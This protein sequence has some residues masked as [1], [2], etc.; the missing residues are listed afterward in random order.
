[1]ALPI[2]FL[3]AAVAGG[4]R[5]QSVRVYSEFQRVDPF[6]AVIAADKADRPRE[7]LSPAVPRNAFV[8]FQAVIAV[9]EGQQYSLFLG[10]NPENA[11]KV[12]AYR[13]VWVKRGDAYIP[14]TLE[15]LEIRDTG[16]VVDDPAVRLPGQ[17][18]RVIWLDLWVPADAP[19]RRTRFEVQMNVGS[20]W[21]IYP[22]ELR[23]S[24]LV[25]PAQQG[26]FEPLPPPEAPASEAAA[27]V[28]RA[29]ICG[30][31]GGGSAEEGPLTVRRLIR[32]NARQDAALARMLGQNAAKAA[33][34]TELL[35]S[36]GAADRAKWCESP[37]GPRP[38]GAEWYLRIR[39]F[40][41]RSN[42]L[43]PSEL[44]KPTVNLKPVE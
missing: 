20:Q 28:M 39:D 18:C 37:A 12:S 36:V 15:P 34:A 25:V 10:Q 4:M 42:P 38:M 14:D 32:R 24:P 21:F 23:V 31:P 8:T 41:L 27:R 30:A 3:A 16:E 43:K 33:L 26:A 1:M 29:Y 19:V 7:V 17:T 13:P 22:L 40:L 2:L 6:C 44:L 35:D 9:A 11:V 5:A